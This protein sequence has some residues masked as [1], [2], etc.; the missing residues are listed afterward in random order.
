MH[1]HRAEQWVVVSGI[2]EVTI[3]E[4]PKILK[5]DQS[6]Y[7]P[8]GSVHRLQNSE[9]SPLTLIEVQS[10]DYLGED[11]IIRLDDQYGRK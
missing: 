2:A 5:E 11:D 3:G 10:G 6:I 8:I 4:K 7:I 9:N 1:H